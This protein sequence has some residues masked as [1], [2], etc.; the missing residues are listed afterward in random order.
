MAQTYATRTGT[1]DA[2]DAVAVPP[3]RLPHLA[4]VILLS[5]VLLAAVLV[6]LIGFAGGSTAPDKAL[7]SSVTDSVPAPT[8]APAA[9]I[10]GPVRP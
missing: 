6:M 9:P 2:A 5:G 7:P 4:W 1:T 8:N 3:A 10:P